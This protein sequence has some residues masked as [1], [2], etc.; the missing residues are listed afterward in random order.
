MELIGRRKKLKLIDIEKDNH[1]T[2]YLEKL[3]NT[4]AYFGFE[5]EDKNDIEFNK[6][7]TFTYRV[8]SFFPPNEDFTKFKY[9]L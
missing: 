7:R 6:W 2:I 9:E 4:S 8:K 1:R 5:L 3:K